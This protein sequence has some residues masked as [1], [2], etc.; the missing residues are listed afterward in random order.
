MSDLIPFRG[1]RYPASDLSACTA[2]PYDVIDDDER[3]VLE[4]R[5]PHNAVRL[6]LPRDDDGC[7][8]YEAAA[9][10]LRDWCARGV[11][12]RDSQPALYGYRILFHDDTSPRVTTG[13]I[14]GLP[15]AAPGEAVLPHERTLARARNDRLAL[16]RATRANLDPIW[17]LSLASGLT[18]LVDA[19]ETPVATARDGDA[20]H[21]L[22]PIT[23]AARI[24]TIRGAITGASM[25]LADGHH[26]Y[27]T[28]AAYARDRDDPAAALIMALVVELTGTQLCVRAIHRL[29]SGE[30]AR[31]LRERLSSRFT[32]TELGPNVP[33]LA[34][35]VEARMD[36]AGALGIVDRD[37]IGLLHPRL[38]AIAPLLRDEPDAVHGV[39][40]AC[41]DA[42]IRPLIGDAVI[43]YRN[44]AATVAALVEK[45]AADAAVL[46]RPVS[47]DQ[48]RSAALAG[49]RMPEKS[50]FFAPKPRTGMVFRTLDES[51]DD[52]SGGPAA[53]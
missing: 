44:D 12:R 50:T 23:D 47:V 49:V 4:E 37:G 24:A 51:G 43:D 16:L 19:G 1:L 8:R 39:D 5:D 48:I 41:F 46:L 36:D 11:L 45:G 27:E 6:I 30:P 15:V 31:S 13:V 3:R 33:E 10:L 21:E 22:W 18:E 34:A 26:R 2:P 29:L 20:L 38:E 52:R 25:V 53:N 40:A 32:L 14:G 42:A 7:D 28:A 9:R 17:V 35:T